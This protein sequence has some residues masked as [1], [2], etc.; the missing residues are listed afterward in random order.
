M[1]KE[2]ELVAELKKKTPEELEAWITV[3][4][5]QYKSGE[6]SKEEYWK[7]CVSYAEAK[8]PKGSDASKCSWVKTEGVWLVVMAN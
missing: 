2:A 1:D 6:I 7:H 3:F 8:H 5:R 4:E